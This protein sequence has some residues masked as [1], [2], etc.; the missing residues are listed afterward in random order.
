[1][2]VINTNVS[3]LIAQTN[4]SRANDQL[5]TALT[6][7]STGLKINSGADNPAGLIASQDLQ[8]DIIG[9]NTGISNS[10]Q[11]N[12]LIATADSALSQ[13]STL[14]DN[15]RG[16][17]SQ[18]ANTGALSQAQVAANQL[19]VDSS[20]QAIDQIANSTT[21]GGQQLLNGSLNFITTTAGQQTTA[22]TGTVGAQAA[23]TA[24]TT[25]G[26]G[27]SAVTV[28]AN[29]TGA[30]ANGYDVQ[31]QATT[32]GATSAGSAISVAF[33][34][35]SS[36]GLT[37]TVA[38]G[39]TA[40][41]AQVAT[42]INGNA[43]AAAVFTAAGG[44]GNV[45]TGT[46]AS[47]SGGADSNQFTLTAVNGGTS[48]NNTNVVLV[49]GGTAGSETASYSATNNTLTVN[50]ASGSSTA[51]DVVSAIN[52]NTAVAAVFTAAGTGTGTLTGGTT[53]GA[54]SGGTATN[55]I[56]NLN[57]N[58]ANFGTA[59]QVNV[60]V[61]IDAQATQGQL[62]YSGGTLTSSLVL[63]VGGNNG[64][65]VFNFASGATNSQI[66]S[67]VNAVSSATGVN[68]SISGGNLVFT[69]QNY[70]S[71]S[72]V[73]VQALSG[74]FNTTDSTNATS[75]RSTGTDVSATINGIQATGN[76][77]QVSLDTPTLNLNFSVDSGL[78]NGSSFNFAITGGGAQFQLGPDVVSNEQARL[79]I[80]SVSTANLGG[81]DGTL[82]ELQ[83]GGS[84]SLA[85]NVNGAGNVIA[86]VIDQVTSLQ[87][88]LGAFQQTT[89]Q[90]NINTLQDTLSNLTSAQ[91][92]IQ[93]ADF[94]VESANLTRA[95]ILV[96]SGTTVLSI[97]NHN[98][99]NV[100]NL[101]K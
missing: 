31:I 29:A 91:S 14:L 56:S 3:S 93:D 24:S 74:S 45:A 15:I 80:Q 58:Q 30:A 84:L 17:V 87:G 22:A 60:G 20:L 38:S 28:T 6:R 42:A 72:F 71:Q 66:E 70:G 11:A 85:N 88:R 57:I 77:L 92:N 97:A 23:A 67:A 37:V 64:Y 59:S 76:G 16:L 50:I 2:T 83:S 48:Y 41:A 95:Q 63:Q 5:N 18:S 25:V 4:L 69:S 99:Q 12:S 73:S 34:G 13:V 98:P 32:S 21:F 49:S 78:T 90:T 96:Q 26:T 39:S 75:T 52:A 27:T 51:A 65:N 9:V 8:S 79:G 55:N 33:S 43:G 61:K 19:Q 7:L 54:T 68:A 100:L 44:A 101:L 53:T 1:M 62:T 94:A 10:Q 40:T 36:G 35:A 46:S 47:T 82:Y 89:L 81:V 86:E